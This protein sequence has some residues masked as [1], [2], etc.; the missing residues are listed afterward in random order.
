MSIQPR[1]DLLVS[2]LVRRVEVAGGFATVLHRGD[3]MGG[4]ILV[5]LLERGRFRGFLERMT[6]LAGH[7]QMVPCGPKEDAQDIEISEYISKRRRVDPD[8]WLIELDV[9]QGQR[10]ADEILCGD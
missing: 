4:I 10:F 7:R 8:L 2:A 3:R 1:T 6:D 9:A 5:Q